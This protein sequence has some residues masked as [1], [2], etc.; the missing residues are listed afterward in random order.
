MEQAEHYPPSIRLI[1]HA[2]GKTPAEVGPMLVQWR[3]TEGLTYP[4][5]A[6]RLASKDAGLSPSRVAELVLEAQGEQRPPKRERP[7]ARKEAVGS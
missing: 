4:E 5:I 7:W 6:D 1:A 2:F 3:N